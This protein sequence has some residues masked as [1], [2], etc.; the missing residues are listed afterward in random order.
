[1]VIQHKYRFKN[2]KLDGVST[3]FHDNGAFKS[4][5]NFDNGI[6]LEKAYSFDGKLNFV[7]CLT[8]QAK[9]TT[10]GYFGRL[11]HL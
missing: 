11:I 4:A 9:E 3:W 7:N 5:T 10:Q 2:D 8:T 1:M 6:K